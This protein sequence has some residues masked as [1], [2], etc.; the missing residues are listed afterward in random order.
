MPF[1]YKGEIASLDLSELLLTR[2]TT[3]EL[4]ELEAFLWRWMKG[5]PPNVVKVLNAI[6]R[7]MEWRAENFS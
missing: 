6:Y 3:R 7:E 4:I 1:V 5:S 2:F